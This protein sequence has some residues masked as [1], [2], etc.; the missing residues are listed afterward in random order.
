MIGIM[1]V[2]D[3]ISIREYINKIK[4]IYFWNMSTIGY[5]LWTICFFILM[6][7]MMVFSKVHINMEKYSSYVEF[8]HT[9][10]NK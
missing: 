8:I 4:F 7:K 3:S 1:I 5:P 6:F 2:K 9:C 10:K